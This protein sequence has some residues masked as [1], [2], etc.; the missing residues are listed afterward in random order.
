MQKTIIQA[1]VAGVIVWVITQK[2]L[3]SLTHKTGAGVA[4]NEKGQFYA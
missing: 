1:V 4:P 2:V 3:P